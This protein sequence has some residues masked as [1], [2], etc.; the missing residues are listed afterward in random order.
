[1]TNNNTQL[2]A[3]DLNQFQEIG[4]YGV[5]EIMAMKDTLGKD[6]SIPQF[7]L[8]VHD[9]VR[10]GLEPRLKHSF[11]ILYGGKMDFRISFE[12]YHSMAQRSEGYISLKT[13]VVTENETDDFYAETDDDGDI[14]K[15]YHKI[16]FP[17][18]KVV[19][20]YAIAKREGKKDLI[21]FCDKPEFEKYAKKNGQ[22]WKLEDGSL[23]PDMCKKHAGT[24]AI[25]AQFAVAAVAEESTEAM[26]GA[27]SA[28]EAPQGRKDITNEVQETSTK[29]T[30]PASQ[31]NTQKDEA[32]PE[33][34]E[35]DV[36]K[37]LAKQIGAALKELG[38]PVGKTDE[39]RAAQQ[40]FY[41]EIGARFSDPN[42]PTI[43]ELQSLVTLLVQQIEMKKLTENDELV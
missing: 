22:F 10:L 28:V 26:Y 33:Q 16:R 5:A 20:A 19:G 27:P 31:Q 39:V 1:M 40:Q 36:M 3:M 25:K 9:S 7:N 32:P 17:R 18:G 11:P 29:Q 30:P 37:G 24:R 12:G 2:Q 41:A 13:E 14:T 43:A 4:N 38:V 35:A 6:L 34:S 21:I 42:A 15:V 23:D 8:F